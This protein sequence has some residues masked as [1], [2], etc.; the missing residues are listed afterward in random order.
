M[1]SWSSA[2]FYLTHSSPEPSHCVNPLKRPLQSGKHYVSHMSDLCVR[3]GFRSVE[4][5]KSADLCGIGSG[6]ATRQRSCVKHK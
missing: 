6:N 4:H 2:R 1:K 5:I 3:C